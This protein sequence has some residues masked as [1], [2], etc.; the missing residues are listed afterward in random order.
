MHPRNGFDP[1]S[2]NSTHNQCILQLILLLSARNGLRKGK[3]KSCQLGFHH[4][5]DKV[6]VCQEKNNHSL[7]DVDKGIA[8]PDCKIYYTEGRNKAA[9]YWPQGCCGKK[10]STLPMAVI[11][12]SRHHVQKD[13]HRLCYALQKQNT[14][15][16]KFLNIQIPINQLIFWSEQGVISKAYDTHL[17]SYRCYNQFAVYSDHHCYFH[18]YSQRLHSYRLPDSYHFCCLQMSRS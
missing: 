2:Y 8:N 15:S 5:S 4:L 18:Y 1:R 17:C 10:A 7:V 14:S 3:H 9:K 6:S 13:M 11:Q 12:Q 16:V